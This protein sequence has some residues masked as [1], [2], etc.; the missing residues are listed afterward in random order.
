MVSTLTWVPFTRSSAKRAILVF[1][2]IQLSLTIV[3]A[4]WVVL[5]ALSFVCSILLWAPAV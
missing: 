3:L 5:L 2:V 4:S 1:D